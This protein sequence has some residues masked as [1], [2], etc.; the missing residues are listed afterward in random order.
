M[1]DNKQKYQTL[2]LQ[3]GYLTC[4]YRIHDNNDTNE[5]IDTII[6]D[7]NYRYLCI[8]RLERKHS[9]IDLV[10]YFLQDALKNYPINS[11]PLYLDIYNVTLSTH[12]SLNYGSILQG[13]YKCGE[14]ES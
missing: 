5:N 4:Y 6:A 9:E 11:K 3:N 14:T 2:R 7:V 12:T 13:I 1:T 10:N 8:P